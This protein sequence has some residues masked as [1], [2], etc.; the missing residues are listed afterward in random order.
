MRSYDYWVTFN[1][2]SKGFDLI[3]DDNST[4]MKVF[5]ILFSGDASNYTLKLDSIEN[6]SKPTHSQSAVCN[7]T[8]RFLVC[9]MSGEFQHGD[10]VHQTDF[11]LS[12]WPRTPKTSIKQD[13]KALLAKAEI[14]D[15]GFTLGQEV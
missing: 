14:K 13:S 12:H 1:S 8:N 9:S 6:F 2:V 11:L 10:H 15:I 3:I 7:T 4:I 5:R